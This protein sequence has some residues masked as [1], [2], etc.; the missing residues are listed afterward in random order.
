MA[1]PDAAI[2]EEFVREVRRNRAPAAFGM[3]VLIAVAN[4]LER[5]EK[6]NTEL[7]RQNDQMHDLIAVEE[8]QRRK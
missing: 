1:L 5:L 2:A 4:E 7:R 6:E 8:R 3:F